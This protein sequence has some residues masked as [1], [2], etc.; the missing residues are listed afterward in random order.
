MYQHRPRHLT[1]PS[2]GALTMAKSTLSPEE[3]LAKRRVDDRERSRIYYIE[4]KAE[5]LKYQKQYAEENKEA[6]RAYKKEW[7]LKTK[8][9]RR[10]YNREWAR[11]NRQENPERSRAA[12]LKQ[13]R[14]WRQAN[15]EKA[16]AYNRE[17]SKA[18]SKANR[19]IRAAQAALRRA[20]VRQAA[21]PWVDQNE[22]LEFYKNC[23]TGMH[24][25]HVVPL[26][27][28]T[29]DGYRVSGLHV[30]WNLQR[31]TELENV[32]KNNRMRLEDH[33]AA[34]APVEAPRQLNLL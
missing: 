10:P 31:L 6:V 33:I 15:L 23:P 20:Q 3:R 16:R 17:Q 7:K 34:N 8:V 24:V 30:P 26:R 18:W 13:A 4:H 1:T 22:L 2:D 14:R 5:R 28:F 11:R 32:R 19:D 21:P 9:A 12:G 25:D 27:G 29:F